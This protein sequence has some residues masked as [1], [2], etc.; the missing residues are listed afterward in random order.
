[1]DTRRLIHVQDV[2]PIFVPGAI[3]SF[4]ATRWNMAAGLWPNPTATR[5][6]ALTTTVTNNRLFSWQRTF[7]QDNKPVRN[8]T[9]ALIQLEEWVPSFENGSA[10][11]KGWLNFG[12]GRMQGIAT[13][14]K[15][16]PVEAKWSAHGKRHLKAFKKHPEITLRLAAFEELKQP[17]A[18]SHIRATMREAIWRMTQRHVDVHPETIDILVA[19][20]EADGIIAAFVAGNCVEASQSVY[21]LGFYLP[22]AIKTY[23]MTGLIAW[24][25]ERTREKNLALCNFGDMCGPRPSPFNKERGYSIF[26]THF[27]IQRTW[28]PKSYWRISIG[29]KP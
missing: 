1:M 29:A 20:T 7:T 5:E 13:P 12:I 21:L 25:F 16:G 15:E 19:E 4:E 22:P 27:G 10:E 26:K 18:G 17:Y 23:A 11:R 2:C 3:P 14:P 28:L 9:S 8:P 24:W 6:Y